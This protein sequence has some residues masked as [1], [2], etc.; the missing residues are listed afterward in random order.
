MFSTMPAEKL[1]HHSVIRGAD[2]YLTSLHVALNRG[3]TPE[4]R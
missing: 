4:K 2:R 1:D 3:Q